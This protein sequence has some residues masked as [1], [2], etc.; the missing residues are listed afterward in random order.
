MLS[1]LQLLLLKWWCNP[2]IRENWVHL[3]WIAWRGLSHWNIR[4]DVI[5]YG[6]GLWWCINIFLWLRLWWGKRFLTTLNQIECFIDD[7]FLK[8]LPLLSFWARLQQY[9][10][11]IYNS[12]KFKTLKLLSLFTFIINFNLFYVFKIY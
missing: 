7:L 1:E 9:I 6:K 4:P 10:R 11:T 3:W 5:I 2:G 12:F 8:F